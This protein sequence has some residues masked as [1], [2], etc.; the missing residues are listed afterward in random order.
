[1]LIRTS[2]VCAVGFCAVL[3]LTQ[4]AAYAQ[5]IIHEQNAATWG[6]ANS[7]L[8]IP[9]GNIITGATLTI[10]NAAFLAATGSETVYIHLLDNP[11]SD[12]TEY[13]D[14]LAGNYFEEYGVYLATFSASDLPESPS[15]IILELGQISDTTSAVWSVFGQPFTLTTFPTAAASQVSYSSALLELLD[16]AGT[17]RSFG[18]GLDC[19]EFSFSGMTLELTIESLSQSTPT[20]ISLTFTIGETSSEISYTYTL[21]TN[22]ANGTVTKSPS[23]TTYTY[24]EVATLTA[25]ANT[26]YT[27]TGWSGDAAGTSASVTVTMNGNKSVTANFSQNTYTLATTATNG[28]IAKSPSKT[29]YTYG[30]AVTLT[31]AANPGYTFTGW[32]GDA[33][34]TSASVTVTMNANK[35]VT[36]NFSPKTYTLTTA[37]ANGTVTKTPSKTTYTYGEVVTLTAAANTGYTFNG[38]SGD[39]TGTSASVTITMNA[40]KSI[41]ANFIQNTNHAPLLNP[42]EDITIVE[43]DRA[44]FTVTA[45]DPDGDPVTITAQGLPDGAT[46]DGSV[47]QWAS[48]YGD[49]GTYEVQFTASDGNKSATITVTITV[50]PVKLKDWYT[51]WLEHLK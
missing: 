33:T 51:K 23:K 37:A 25:A 16:Y 22:A 12:I 14:G 24:G 45:V 7:E 50:E 6:I 43:K 28:T 19:D 18:F 31:A 4:P 11:D 49:A 15:D 35:S 42:I 9:A 34:G 8:N 44:N 40:N 27:F 38:W 1:M 21:A 17:G 2:Y 48:W 3:M 20:E 26:G 10:H 41:T 39:A 36:A 47:F 29:T 46:F 5:S 30:E 32:S 13:T